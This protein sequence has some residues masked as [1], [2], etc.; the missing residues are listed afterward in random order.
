[1]IFITFNREVHLF[2]NFWTFKTL[3][4]IYIYIYIYV[5]NFIKKLKQIVETYK[6][7][8][9]NHSYLAKMYKYI[10]YVLLNVMLLETVSFLY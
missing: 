5:A 3:N 2:E 4:I 1:M 10:L 9:K 7:Q 6:N 8:T